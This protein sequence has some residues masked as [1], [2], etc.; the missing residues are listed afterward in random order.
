LK[1]DLLKVVE[2]YH[3]ESEK[4]SFAVQSFVDKSADHNLFGFASLAVE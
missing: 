3:T 2:N 1:T 4:Y